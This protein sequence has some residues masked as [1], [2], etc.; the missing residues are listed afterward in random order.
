[1]NKYVKAYHFFTKNRNKIDT[2][3]RAD[4]YIRKKSKKPCF[5]SVFKSILETEQKPKTSLLGKKT[6]K[7]PKNSKNQKKIKKTHWAGFFL[8]TLVFPILPGV[9]VL[10]DG[11]VLELG[12]HG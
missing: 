12:H 1:M 9:D 8:K 6:P 11:R 10:V 4:A 2:Q 5:F 7:N 3:S